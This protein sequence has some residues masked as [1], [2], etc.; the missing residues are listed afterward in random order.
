MGRG[1]WVMALGLAGVLA[2]AGP[3]DALVDAPGSPTQQQPF[4]ETSTHA[5]DGGTPG[6][7][8]PDAG[9]G[10]SDAGTPPPPDAGGFPPVQT[11]VPTYTLHVTPEALAALDANPESDEQVPVVVELDGV[12][13]PGLM[14]YRGASTRTLPQKSFKIKL[15]PGYELEDRDHFELLASWSD[16]GKLTEK[17]AV[18]LYAA[19][20]LPVPRAR[21]AQ[22]SLNG[23]PNGLYLDV[24]H[25]GKDFLKHHG[26]ERK[27]SIYRCGGRNCELTLQP[28][29]YQDD[30]EKKTNEDTGWEDLA[31]LLAVVNR[32]D[33]SELE[34]WLAAHVDLEAYL[35]NLAADA[36]ISNNVIEDSRSYWVHEPQRD[37]WTYVPWDLNN[38]RMLYWRTWEA[39]L[40][41]YTKHEPRL[42]SLYDPTVQSTWQQRVA[43]KTSQ[44]PTWSVL[45]TRL[46]DRPALRERLLAKLEAAMAGPFTEEQAG[47]HIDALWRVVGPELEKDPYVSREH[48][49]RARSFL[50]DYVR[51]RR[52]YL[53]KLLATLRAHGSGPLV[54]REVSAGSRGYIEVLNRGTQPLNLQG[55][56]VTNDLR[57]PSKYRL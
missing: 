48:V 11:R 43:Q 25:V 30:F 16:G 13:A 31:A 28:G 14:R 52:T 8:T 33:D 24:E 45:N 5:Q 47:A 44:R 36:L 2:C 15:D 56:G 53:R 21:Y 22:V 34:A 50:K 18:D 7:R 12:R 6:P 26:M 51:G 54:L 42:F 57:E 3:E 23:Q 10:A 17:F 35:G 32:S 40:P 55:Y 27:A 19:L 37:V 29:S 4:P 39:D 41:P 38:A 9:S 1:A 49:S 46:W 20:G